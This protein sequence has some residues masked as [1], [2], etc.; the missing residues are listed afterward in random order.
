MKETHSTSSEEVFNFKGAFYSIEVCHSV[1]QGVK[2]TRVVLQG[3]DKTF[4][5]SKTDISEIIELLQKAQEVQEGL[6]D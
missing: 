6:L 2:K 1:H 4:T 5:L 3:S